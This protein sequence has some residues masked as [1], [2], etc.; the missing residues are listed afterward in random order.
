MA[1]TLRLSYLSIYFSVRGGPAALVQ[2]EVDATHYD[3]AARVDGRVGE[4]AVVRG[5]EYRCKRGFGAD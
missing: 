2:G 3:I 5:R 4:V 1:I